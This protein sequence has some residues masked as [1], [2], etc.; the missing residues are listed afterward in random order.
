MKIFYNFC[1]LIFSTFGFAQVGIGTTIPEAALHVA[2]E[3]ATVRL[4]SLSQANN[5]LN[6]GTKL[7]PSYVEKNGN[8]TLSSS[9]TGTTSI[10]IIDASSTFSSK[11]LASNIGASN[12]TTNIYS[13]QIITQ[14]ESFIEVKYSLSYNI[15][16]SYNMGNQTGI[17]IFDGESRQIKT[18][19]TIT[20][21][22]NEFGQISQNYYNIS[23]NGGSGTFYNNGFDYITLPAG[24]YTINF[25]ANIAGHV[26]NT[27]EVLF[28]G[29]ESLLR[30][31]FYQ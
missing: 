4:E 16:A 17:R 1:L 22:A 10:S 23:T 30:L 15:F 11:V 18:F 19:F 20:G 2:G 8:I 25:Y 7:A 9:Q 21:I 29:A 13:Y 31:R 6:D 3:S 14:A 24:T 28:G 26:N 27:T 5:V 12:T